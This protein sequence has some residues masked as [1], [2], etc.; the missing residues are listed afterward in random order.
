VTLISRNISLKTSLDFPTFA[1]TN[2]P[3]AQSTS[4]NGTKAN[5]SE[6]ANKSGKTDQSTRANSSTTSSMA[7][8]DSSTRTEMCMKASLDSLKQRATGYTLPISPM[9]SILGSGSIICSMVMELKSGRMI[10]NF[11][12]RG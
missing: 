3:T 12:E 9:V 6:E 10:R 11:L 1:L 2:Y 5:N 8:A 7:W 4:A